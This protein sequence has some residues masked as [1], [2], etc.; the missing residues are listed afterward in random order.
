MTPAGACI[1][2]QGSPEFLA[3]KAKG[4]ASLSTGYNPYQMEV[5]D[6][7]TTKHT[8]WLPVQGDEE[9][10]AL[11]SQMMRV[12]YRLKWLHEHPRKLRERKSHT[13]YIVFLSIYLL[14]TPHTKS[15]SSNH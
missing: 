11:Q 7:L 10:Y 12:I 2:S 4:L 13:Q 14:E 6:V 9:L 5:S 3:E 15:L 8:T 1:P